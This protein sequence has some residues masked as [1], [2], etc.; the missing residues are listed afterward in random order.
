[1]LSTLGKIRLQ[2]QIFLSFY[3]EIGFWH[4]MQTASSGDSLHEI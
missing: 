2:F 3:Q 1:M 4:F